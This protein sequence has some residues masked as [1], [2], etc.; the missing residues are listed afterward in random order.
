[1]GVRDP[2][3]GT[4][5]DALN[6]QR[7]M[8][9]EMPAAIAELIDNSFEHGGKTVNVK[10]ELLQDVGK[11]R[12]PKYAI[13]VD[14]GKGMIPEKLADHLQIGFH[15][16]D[17]DSKMK[18][19]KFG[20]GAKYA[21]FN[22]CTKSEVWSKA[23]DGDWH[24]A[25]FDLN[26]EYLKRKR[27]DTYIQIIMEAAKT[28]LEVDL[29]V[30]EAKEFMDNVEVGYP[31]PAI[32]QD[33]P[34]EFEDL[35]SH[36]EQGTFVMWSDFDRGELGFG[37]EELEWYFSRIYRKWI[38]D[39]YVSAV[40]DTEI[41]CLTTILTDNANKTEL[42]YNGT[43]LKAYDPLYRIPFRDG[44]VLSEESLKEWTPIVFEYPL[45]KSARAKYGLRKSLI[46]I[47]FGL[48]P[49]DWRTKRKKS[50]ESKINV[51]ERRIQGP[52]TS[53]SGSNKPFWNSQVVSMVR[54]GRE[55]A[56]IWDAHLTGVGRTENV[57]RWWGMEIE[58]DEC[59]DDAFNVQNVKS[60]TGPNADLRKKIKDQVSGT[61]VAMREKITEDF[62]AFAHEQE[63]EARRRKREECEDRGGRFVGGRCVFAGEDPGPIDGPEPTVPENPIDPSIVPL[64]TDDPEEEYERWL[65]EIFG[66]SPLVQR[67]IEGFESDTRVV[68]EEDNLDKRVPQDTSMMFEFA[69]RGG[70]LLK[71]RYANHPYHQTLKENYENLE[72]T[73]V[74]MQAE[75]DDGEIDKETMSGF[76]NDISRVFTETQIIHDHSIN[77]ALLGMA[78][79][80]GGDMDRIRLMRQVVAQWSNINLQLTDQ[81]I[82]DREHSD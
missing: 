81:L 27:E 50:A 24:K 34:S 71:V 17:E 75:I 1:M 22:N 33:P 40:L 43:L 45:S 63:V 61:I 73:F 53:K 55:V 10:I 9:I 74:Q 82:R 54:Q 11:E 65:R 12:I 79:A 20:V 47:N 30:T 68:H 77:S 69:V 5:Y 51:L 26:D 48:C 78:Q 6:S 66:D 18:F 29:S 57:D 14:D 15:D 70:R 3:G 64:I 46:T 52:T 41:E 38:G 58:F 23:K 37:H 44:D 56:A 80:Q 36:L 7:S 72:G 21:F 19:G 28:G 62:D 2:F 49:P 35:W 39:Q 76:I 4:Y 8:N 32:R 25:E 67:I 13:V 60:R 59:L 16:E 31:F 42:Y